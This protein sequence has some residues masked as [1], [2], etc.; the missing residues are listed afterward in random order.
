MREGAS[1]KLLTVGCWVG[2]LQYMAYYNQ[3]AEK[4]KIPTN[5]WL[6]GTELWYMYELKFS[7]QL[8]FRFWY[9]VL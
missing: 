5:P 1:T 3:K 7:W 2:I 8:L 9:S 6:P 4:S